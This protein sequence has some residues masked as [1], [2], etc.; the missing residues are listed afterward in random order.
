MPFNL[1]L[2]QKLS[3]LK[4]ELDSGLLPQA[5]YEELCRSA[6]LGYGANAYVPG[7][8]VQRELDNN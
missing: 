4:E 5:I 8:F 3:V 2:R 1:D 7:K 6:I